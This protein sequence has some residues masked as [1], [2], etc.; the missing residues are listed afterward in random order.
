MC[1]VEMFA[2]VLFLSLQSAASSMCI[3]F[4]SVLF[5]YISHLEYMFWH[6]MFQVALHGPDLTHYVVHSVLKVAWICFTETDVFVINLG[7]KKIWKKE[8]F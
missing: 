6:F 4:P 5:F 2:H 3:Q 8:I 1:R 7:K